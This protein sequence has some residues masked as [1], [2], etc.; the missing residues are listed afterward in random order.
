VSEARGRRVEEPVC[1]VPPGVPAPGTTALSV[2]ANV[3]C[4]PSCDGFL[5]ELTMPA[6]RDLFAV[7]VPLTCVI[8]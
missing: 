3:T 8:V 7:S 1:T 2:T 4:S 5:D 6:V